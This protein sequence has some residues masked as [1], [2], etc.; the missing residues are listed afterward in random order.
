[1]ADTGTEFL[2]FT[3]MTS[4]EEIR[5]RL[6]ADPEVR[7]QLENFSR[8]L[9]A[10]TAAAYKEA[11]LTDI[12]GDQR[13]FIDSE[14]E[15]IRLLAPAGAGKTSTVINRVLHLAAGGRSPGE[16]LILTFDNSAQTSLMNRLNEALN[17]RQLPDKPSIATLNGFG[18]RFLLAYY[19]DLERQFTVV[20]PKEAVPLMI[21]VLNELKQQAPQAARAFPRDTLHSLMLRIV[22][23]LKNEIIY[24]KELRPK[25][26]ISVLQEYSAVR[27]VVTA[28]K[29]NA[30]DELLVYS[31]II[32]VYLEY[33]RRLEKLQ[34]I[35]F[36]DQK[37]ITYILFR[38]DPALCQ[39]YMARYRQV[40]VDE[41]Q[42]IN[43]LDFSL[44]EM[45]ARER[46]LIAVGDDDQAIY[47]FRGSK[48][49]YL[50]SLEQHLQRKVTTHIL[51]YNYRCPA[52]IV[53]HASLLIAHNQNRIPK[54]MIPAREDNA[55]IHLFTSPD[56][57]REA[58]QIAHLIRLIMHDHPQVRYQDFAILMRMNA[59]SILLQL[60]FIH[61]QI[62][63]YTRLDDNIVESSVFKNILAFFELHTLIQ[64]GQA[65]I[66]PRFSSLLIKTYFKYADKAMTEKFHALAKAH[67]DYLQAA[68]EFTEELD[69]RFEQQAQFFYPTLLQL[70]EPQSAESLIDLLLLQFERLR[71][72]SPGKTEDM[73][74]IHPGLQLLHIA[75]SSVLSTEKFYEMLAEIAR[76]G[77]E[78]RLAHDQQDGD[79]VNILTYF[80]AKGQQWPHVFIVGAN[81]GT[82]PHPMAD[83]E[84]ERRLFYVAMTRAR[85]SMTISYISP[86]QKTD[87]VPSQFISEAGLHS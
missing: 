12:D 36:D 50:I 55:A 4:I 38:D 79:N 72:P 34:Q 64:Q 15:V 78:G 85:H 82:T 14:A 46:K 19:R 67:G 56:A 53:K 40:I 70:F 76:R 52:N 3:L 87:Q 22:S 83:M 48:P 1:M 32:A 43:L 2:F 77:R 44:I 84:T 65:A 69:N 57:M 7:E 45:I 86:T 30:E 59:Q 68:S 11:T 23:R 33:C 41:F 13:N 28:A 16:T 26:A 81:Q 35:D 8:Q 54:E 47:T 62:P 71:V 17:H 18:N 60:V 9:S 51:R 5:A 10:E 37:L 6:Q 42:D 49:E 39:Q 29:L 73:E 25:D 66:Q 58:A 61:E 74:T 20:T 75:R 27:N 63:Y 31:F 24:F 80:K 21:S